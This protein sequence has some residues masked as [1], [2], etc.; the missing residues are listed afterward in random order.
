[1]TDNFNWQQ[2]YDWKKNCHTGNTLVYRE[3]QGG[4]LYIGGWNQ[5]AYF[6]SNFHVIDLTGAE[7]KFVFQAEAFDDISQKF[8]P[9]MNKAY[10][11]WLS[12]PF[13]DYGVPRNISTYEQWE[14]I[15]LTIQEIL[16]NGT[17]VLVACHGGHGRSG[18]FC[19]IVGYILGH[20]TNKE[21]ANPVV[22][23]RKI[24]CDSAVETLEQEKFVYNVLGLRIQI[25]RTYQT[26]KSWNKPLKTCSLCGTN[27]A[28]TDTYGMCHGCMTKF[29]NIAPKRHDLTVA[30]IKDKGK[31]AHDCDNEHCMGIWKA[32]ICNHVTHNMIVYEG[33]CAVCYA[34]AE[35]LSHTEVKAKTDEVCAICGDETAYSG[36]FGVCYECAEY[37]ATHGEADMVHNSITDPYKSVVHTCTNDGCVGVMIADICGHVI[38]DREVE[39]GLCPECLL[40]KAEGK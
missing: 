18:L 32:D 35:K 4:G 15:A 7:H 31:V 27:S 8:M 33:L 14:G 38:H 29:Q 2:Q 10:A 37:V 5:E 21:W 9:F 20:A 24:H 17:D 30:D 1:M 12:L 19:A 36:R 3:S 40:A 6:D 26:D 22:H 28:F 13:P 23:I 39:D 34:R 16:R 11:G 25:S